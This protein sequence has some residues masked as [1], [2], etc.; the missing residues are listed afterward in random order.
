MD[1]LNVIDSTQLCPDCETI[2]TSRSRHCSVCGHCIER[3]DHHCPWI[4]NCVGLKN[5]NAFLCYLTF[6]ILVIYSTFAM[7]VTAFVRYL[8]HNDGDLS[9]FNSN[10]YVIMPEWLQDEVIIVAGLAAVTC[11]TMVFIPPVSLLYYVQV[12]NFMVGRTTMERHGRG[13][14]DNDREN[15]IR[16]SG[17]TDDMQVYRSP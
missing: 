7:S 2:R 15:R 11:L 10:F 8:T 17:I 9:K 4:N 14:N 13:A 3:F 1:M 16:N 12:R 5:H 6:Q